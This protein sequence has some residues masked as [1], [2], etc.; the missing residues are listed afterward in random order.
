MRNISPD[1][2][3]D[4]FVG[5]LSMMQ[6]WLWIG[7][8]AK[9]ADD[10]GRFVDNVMLIRSMLFPYDTDVT[11]KDI[12]KALTL[13]DAKHKITRYNIGVNGSGK[14]LIQIN[15]WWKF[16]KSA[17]WAGRSQ[18]DAPPK[19]NDRI[20]A[21]EHGGGITLMNWDSAGGYEAATKPLRSAK[22]EA[23]KP[24]QSRDVNVN[25]KDDVN[26]KD[27]LSVKH[28]REI[29]TRN[30][31]TIKA[32]DYKLIDEIFPTV[33]DE[34]VLRAVKIARENNKHSAAYV[35]GILKNWRA[36]HANI[37]K[38]GKQDAKPEPR[39]PGAATLAAAKRIIERKRAETNV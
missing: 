35:L 24:L 17:Q 20:R 5:S 29:F 23:T 22:V 21:H 12:E 28:A 9:V 33:K 26:V 15:N 6:R 8:L 19:W 3:M 16:Q 25:V 14:K 11:V 18:Y 30:Q 1:L 36:E 38:R 10:Q 39:Q 27:S 34:Q 4:E 7:L 32:A 31:I 13:F 2:F 37:S